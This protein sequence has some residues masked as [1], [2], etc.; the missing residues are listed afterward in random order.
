[1]KYLAAIA[2]IVLCAGYPPSPREADQRSSS[3]KQTTNTPDADKKP[4]AKP[5]PSL[6]T[7][8][9][10]R[11]DGQ[12]GNVIPDN[13]D[14][15]VRVTSIS[16][17]SIK[18]VKDWAD[19]GYWAFT[20]L[21]VVV[22]FLQVW[23]LHRTLGAIKRQASLLDRQAGIMES[24]T[25]HLE[26]SV[27]VARDAA[28]AA[29]A[30]VDAAI[31]KERA[32]IK[33]GLEPINPSSQQVG[34]NAVACWLMNYG[35]TPAFIDDFRARFLHAAQKEIVSDYAQC[36]QVL[37]AE[38]L[39]SNTRTPQTF[40]V[41][42]EPNNGSLAEQEVMSIRKGESFLHYYGFVKYRDVF[43]RNRRTTIHMRWTMRWGGMIQGQIMQ[44]WDPVGSPQENG[45]T[46]DRSP[47]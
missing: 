7:R 6:D 17:V 23:L 12:T 5:T 34:F 21:L 15:P 19:W 24:Q 9:A 38:S 2:V 35:P 16:P 4:S 14:Q 13:K 29:Q 45:D 36:R 28:K 41:I 32:R 10:D 11:P 46:E 20:G 33:I 30:S 42:L 31:N 27:A 47:N 43:N 39:Q 18:S 1:M 44:W 8:N 37:Y 25:S 22:G 26:D 3:A 40:L